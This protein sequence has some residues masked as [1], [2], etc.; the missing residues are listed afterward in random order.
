MVSLLTFVAELFASVL[1]LAVIF[2][3]EVALRDPLSFVSFAVGAVLTTGA[4]VV[5]GYL[6]L[7]ALVDAL[8]GDF[9]FTSPGREP[10]QRGE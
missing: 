2:V 4:V 9:D 6:A 7:G 5:F 1:R 10:P 3:T 8:V